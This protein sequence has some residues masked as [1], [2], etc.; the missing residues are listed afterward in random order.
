MSIESKNLSD[1][2]IINNNLYSPGDGSVNNA[3]DITM[4]IN[5]NM[6]N[7]F[8]TNEINKI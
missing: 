8:S 2:S 6:F 3:L 1:N 5:S 4:S 7:N